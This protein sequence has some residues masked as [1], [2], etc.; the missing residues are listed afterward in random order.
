MQLLITDQI[1]YEYNYTVTDACLQRQP[2]CKGICKLQGLAIH[3]KRY[4][5]G[6][7]Y[8]KKCECKFNTPK[9]SCPCCGCSLRNGPRRRKH[10]LEYIE[11][12]Q[13]ILTVKQ[14]EKQKQDERRAKNKHKVLSKELQNVLSRISRHGLLGN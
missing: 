9:R 12:I 10:R 6:E 7:K 14:R 2:G 5:P 3:G 1:R 13:P 4:K 8:C 11:P